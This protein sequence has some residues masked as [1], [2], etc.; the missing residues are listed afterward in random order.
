MSQV[1]EAG[2]IDAVILL[3]FPTVRKVDVS[4][5]LQWLAR[6]VMDIRGIPIASLFYGFCFA[7]MG[8]LLTTLL[9][10]AYQYTA[11]LI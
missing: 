10:Q 4:R 8:L 2:S 5:P 9:R 3:P 7:A 6:A 1:K 11:A